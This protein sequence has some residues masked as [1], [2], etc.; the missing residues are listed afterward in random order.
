MLL[1]IVCLVML[2]VLALTAIFL[3]FADGD[4]TLIWIEH[5]GRKAGECVNIL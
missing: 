1:I 4:L 2:V 5:F 3:L